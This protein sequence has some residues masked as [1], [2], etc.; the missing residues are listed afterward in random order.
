MSGVTPNSSCTSPSARQL[1]LLLKYGSYGLTGLPLLFSMVLPLTIQLIGPPACSGSAWLR[2]M[3]TVPMPSEHSKA[4]CS[5]LGELGG[6]RDAACCSR[7]MAQ[8]PAGREAQTVSPLSIFS[9]KW[10]R[11]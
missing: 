7:A 8:A 2:F 10:Y 3:S 11:K 6:T 5:G 1:A 9:P 4:I